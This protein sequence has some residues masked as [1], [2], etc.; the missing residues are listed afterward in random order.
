MANR[1]FKQFIK[2]PDSELVHLDGYVS[3]GGTGAVVTQTVSHCTVSRLDVGKY[4]LT[5]DNKYP[6]LK[7]VSVVPVLKAA[8]ADISWC[9]L[10]EDVDGAKT[11]DI[12][13]H[14]TGSA[15]ELASGNGFLVHLCLKNSGLSKGR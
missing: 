6:S 9:L 14:T 11:V 5:L 7:S 15:A 12:Q 13:F 4:R 3:V 8:L 10:D 2:T 1:L